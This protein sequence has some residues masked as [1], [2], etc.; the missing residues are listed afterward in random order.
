MYHLSSAQLHLRCLYHLSN[1][2][3]LIRIYCE[4]FS[5][6]GGALA[7]SRGVALLRD[8]ISE[9]DGRASCGTCVSLRRNKVA[10]TKPL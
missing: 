9:G 3:S 2:D 6:R 7:A 4:L 1:A 8:V 5:P 10:V